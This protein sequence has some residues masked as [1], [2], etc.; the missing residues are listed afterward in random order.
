MSKQEVK[1]ILVETDKNKYLMVR[2]KDGTEYNVNIFSGGG[3]YDAIWLQTDAEMEEQAAIRREEER[4][5]SAEL[6]AKAEDR[7]KHWWN[8]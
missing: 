8:R 7:K 2:T 5:W 3:Y 4:Q 1:L 6:H